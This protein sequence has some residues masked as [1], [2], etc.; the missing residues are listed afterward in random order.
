MITEQDRSA[1]CNAIK[2]VVSFVV[3]YPDRVSVSFDQGEQTLVVRV[4]VE[5]S[6]IGKIIGKNGKMADCL[7]TLLASLAARRKI[8]AV[9]SIEE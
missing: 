5:K 2:I 4:Y 8:R 1:I 3:D 9:L 6:D 7:R